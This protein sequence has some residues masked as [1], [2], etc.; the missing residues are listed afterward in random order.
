MLPTPEEEAAVLSA[1]GITPITAEQAAAAYQ[2]LCSS[3][4]PSSI[5]PPA[6]GLKQFASE[7]AALDA[8]F[9]SKYFADKMHPIVIWPE[10]E[11][12][13]LL[14]SDLGVLSQGLQAYYQYQRKQKQLKMLKK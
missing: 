13:A 3:A 1:A 2:A 5:P 8:H 6:A 10:Q 9:S 4:D 11:Q 12:N 14:H 7:N